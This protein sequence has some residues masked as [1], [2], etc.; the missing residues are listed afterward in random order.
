[1]SR[2]LKTELEQI[3]RDSFTT[4]QG[5]REQ[6]IQTERHWQGQVNTL[7]HEQQARAEQ[8]QDDLSKAR[9]EVARIEGQLSSYSFGREKPLNIGLLLVGA[10]L[11]GV[12]LV[13][14]VFVVA[15]LLT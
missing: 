5:L 6:V 11:F 9:A 10:I 1:M 12:L 13:I 3:R 15:N 4:E 2:R 8:L 7:K 14:V